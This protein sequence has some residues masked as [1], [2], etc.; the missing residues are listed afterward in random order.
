V[1]E[2]EWLSCPDPDPMLSFLAS[3]GAADERRLR[4]VACACVRQAWQ[5]LT[6][7][8]R[9]AIEMAEANAEGAA[10]E[11]E[12]ARARWLV[13][14]LPVGDQ[15]AR[16]AALAVWHATWDVRHRTPDC[17]WNL[18]VALHPVLGEEGVKRAQ[19]DI[20]RDLYGPLPFRPV[21]LDPRWRTRDVLTVAHAVHAHRAYG[22]LPAVADALEEAGCDCRELLD[23]LRNGGPHYFGCW[24]LDLVTGKR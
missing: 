24:G 11:E 3:Q 5:L 10:T 19:A 14:R 12:V 22:D 9:V 21:A 4:L 7:Q 13:D 8:A 17:L 16:S 15:T 23:H 1:T 6:P 20:L 2:S 18:R